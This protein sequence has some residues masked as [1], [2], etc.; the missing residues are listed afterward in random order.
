MM[1]EQR[2]RTEHRKTEDRG[3][4]DEQIEDIEDSVDDLRGAV[5]I[6]HEPRLKP[7]GRDNR[8]S[9]GNHSI[10]KVCCYPQRHV[11]G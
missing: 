1:L 7:F 8:R 3:T 10:Q 2:V 4:D 5:Q 9:F 11:L 6:G